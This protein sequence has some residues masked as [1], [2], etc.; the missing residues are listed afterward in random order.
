MKHNLFRK[1]LLASVLGCT[2]LSLIAAPYEIIDLG[3]ITGGSN[4]FGW[5]INDS[6]YVAGHADGP[7]REN[8]QLRLFSGHA[9]LHDKSSLIDLGSIED[10][11]SYA[12]K[13]NN[14]NAATGFVT[15]KKDE[16]LSNG[17]TRSVEYDK[18]SIF[19]QGTTPEII[20]FPNYNGNSRALSINNAGQI[21]G[22]AEQQYTAQGA[23][24][25]FVAKRAFFY[26]SAGNISF[27]PILSDNQ[28]VN[29]DNYATS[30]NNNGT[31]VGWSEKDIGSRVKGAA[32][33]VYNYTSQLIE[34]PNLGGRESYLYDINDSNIAVGRAQD[35]RGSYKSILFDIAT[36]KVTEIPYYNQSYRQSKAN[37][38]NNSN[39][40]VGETLVTPTVAPKY[41]AYIYENEKLKL[42][43]DM[44][45]CKSGWDLQF[46]NDINEKGE[47]VGTGSYKGEVRAFKLIPTGGQVESC[48]QSSGSSGGGNIP[49][50]T[51]ILLL[52]FTLKRKN[53]KL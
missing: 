44:I 36:K 48:N 22:Y 11:N 15:V 46:A 2:S 20:T 13:I 52:I 18:A 9:F 19:N 39:Q 50:L 34:V 7:L 21:V 41:A 51:L 43:N 37:A 24:N 53:L 12:Y 29:L 8:S 49:L 30:V 10:G 17:N 42:L 45:A 32:G 3:K 16:Q 27:F 40:V 47:I 5:G 35:S 26:R 1:T 28:N 14:S 31:V 6:G 23:T 25:P 38:I 33:I 4:S